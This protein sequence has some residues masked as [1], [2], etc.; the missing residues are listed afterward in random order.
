MPEH[1][2]VVLVRAA[3]VVGD[4][5]HARDEVG[6]VRDD[7]PRVA[8]GAEVLARVEAEAGGVAQAARAPALASRRRGP[9]PRPRAPAARGASA[10]SRIALH[11]GRLAVEVDRQDHLRARRERRLELRGVH[12]EGVVVHVHEDG[13]GAVQEDRL[14]G[15]DERVRH[16]HDLVAR[17]PRRSARSASVSASVPFATPQ[18]WRAPQKAAN[19]CSNRRAFLAPDELRA[20]HHAGDRRVDLR[21]IRRYCARRST[22]GTFHQ[23]SSLPS[24]LRD[25]TKQRPAVPPGSSRKLAPPR[26]SATVWAFAHVLPGAHIGA[27]CNICDHVFVENDA[28][29]VIASRSSAESRSGTGSGSPTMSSDRT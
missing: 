8:V 3:A 16:R 9:G 6:V 27:D 4:L 20:G 15:G 22:I 7:H 18:A 13:R 10:T 5:P 29:W 24:A 28:V 21:R 25:A 11:V 12:R 19:S 23:P 26:F 2:V 1:D 14:A 17:R